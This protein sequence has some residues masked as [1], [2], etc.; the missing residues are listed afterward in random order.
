MLPSC[1]ER[2]WRKEETW[3]LEANTFLVFQ[4]GQELILLAP[5]G[6]AKNTYI[7]C[8]LWDL[9]EMNIIFKKESQLL[10]EQMVLWGQTRT[11]KGHWLASGEPWGFAPPLPSPPV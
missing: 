8:P 7:M 4:K 1:S 11:G 6:P 2:T 3:K 9:T 10:Q 5:P